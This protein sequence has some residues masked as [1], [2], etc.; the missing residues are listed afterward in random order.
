MSATKSKSATFNRAIRRTAPCV[1]APASSDDEG[2][3]HTGIGLL[4]VEPTIGGA[5]LGFKGVKKVMAWLDD[6]K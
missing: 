6:N 2:W 5:Y 3:L 1:T 4:S